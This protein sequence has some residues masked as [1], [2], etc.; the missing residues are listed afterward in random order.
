M[1]DPNEPRAPPEGGTGEEPE[2]KRIREGRRW[3]I[4]S[5]LGHLR[6]HKYL[7]AAKILSDLSVPEMFVVT[8]E[9]QGD[10]AFSEAKGLWQSTALAKLGRKRLGELE[11]LLTTTDPAL[12]ETTPLVLPGAEIDYYRL[13]LSDFIIHDCVKFPSRDRHSTLSVKRDKFFEKGTELNYE[14]VS[15]TV[16]FDVADGLGTRFTFHETLFLI[17]NGEYDGQWQISCTSD[18]GKGVNIGGNHIIK[19]VHAIF[20]PVW[21]GNIVFRHGPLWDSAY[22]KINDI[23]LSDFWMSVMFKLMYGILQI[24]HVSFRFEVKK[25]EEVVE[26]LNLKNK[27]SL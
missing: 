11:K 17:E 12:P 21:F 26:V 13:M 6:D 10:R 3:W 20:G 15:N 23:P 14:R 24:P 25:D 4:N 9:M 5:L 7:L 22:A 27:V 2:A 1:E 16:V 19:T 8:R 18:D